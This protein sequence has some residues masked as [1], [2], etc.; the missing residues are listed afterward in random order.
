MTQ[1]TA[2]IISRN[3]PFF[4]F[5]EIVILVE[6]FQ[7]TYVRWLDVHTRKEYPFSDS[8]YGVRRMLERD[9]YNYYID[10]QNAKLD[11]YLVDESEL[12]HCSDV[13]QYN[14]MNAAISELEK[15]T[16]SE[17]LNYTNA[18]IEE[19]PQTFDEIMFDEY[20]KG[21]KPTTIANI[22]RILNKIYK[23]PS[24]ATDADYKQLERYSKIFDA[25][26]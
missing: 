8:Q 4:K 2:V 12:W 6:D 9:K 20:L 18:L 24:D 1:N 7:Q 21:I 16:V 23:T 26:K 13:Y 17:H 14:Q 25:C 10:C 11:L 15:H 22:Q 5:G 19:A 3:N